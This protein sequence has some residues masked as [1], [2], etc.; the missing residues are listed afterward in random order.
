[1]PVVVIFT[2]FDALDDL[3]FQELVDSGVSEEEAVDQAKTYSSKL[4]ERTGILE[5]LSISKYPPKD[6][7]F[8]R[9][10]KGPSLKL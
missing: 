7:A 10:K 9:G 4:F 1:M 3:A 8:L 2:K 6:F 5:K